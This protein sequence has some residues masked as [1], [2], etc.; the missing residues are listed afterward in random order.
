M[1]RFIRSDES[2]DFIRKH[3]NMPES[4]YLYIFKH[5]IGPGT[6]PQDVSIIKTKDLPN[7]YTAVW[8]D[9]WLTTSELKK[10][11]IPSEGD[12]R[13]YLDRIGY[14]VTD[15]RNDVVP[16]DKTEV[17]ASTS[18][19]KYGADMCSIGAANTS[20]ADIDYCIYYNG[21][22]YDFDSDLQGQIKKL[23]SMIDADLAKGESVNFPECQVTSVALTVSDDGKNSTDYDWDSEQVEYC[24]D[25]DDDY[26]KYVNATTK[27]GALKQSIKAS[28]HDNRYDENDNLY[29]YAAKGYLQQNLVGLM[30]EIY[31]N[32]FQE[33]LDYATEMSS[34]LYIE[35]QNQITGASVVVTPEDW[36]EASEYGEY[37]TKVYTI[38]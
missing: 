10:Y 18:T 11:D 29:M 26:A 9:R 28:S 36:D 5:G 20:K 7:Y 38:V 21:D 23:K 12:I 15:G 31:S 6:I 3:Q 30:D 22:I 2:S 35:L 24:A 19:T 14:C 27:S 33:V 4:G 25:T 8:L 17:G 16:C 34:G 13:Y 1:K 32:D 37:P